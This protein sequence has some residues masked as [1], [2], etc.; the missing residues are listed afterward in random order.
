MRRVV[1]LLLL[2]GFNSKCINMSFHN[3]YLFFDKP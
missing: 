3:F 1:K 2:Y